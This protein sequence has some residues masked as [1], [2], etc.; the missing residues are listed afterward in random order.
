MI[1]VIH[2]KLAEH[3]K[4]SFIGSK[5]V[6]F[7]QVAQHSS[8]RN[9]IYQIDHGNLFLKDD[10]IADHVFYCAYTGE[11]LPD[12]IKDDMYIGTI[13]RNDGL[14]VHVFYIGIE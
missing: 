6:K 11:Q 4:C 14:V 5:S 1:K 2:K 13:Q 9:I 8:G 3:G 7:L 10:E 12:E